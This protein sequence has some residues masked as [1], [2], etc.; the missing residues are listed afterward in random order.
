MDSKIRETSQQTKA[1]ETQSIVELKSGACW[2]VGPEAG[3]GSTFYGLSGTQSAPYDTG[4]NGPNSLLEICPPS[5]RSAT[6]KPIN[7]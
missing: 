2:A 7:R 4:T 6:K 1:S 5:K 3:N